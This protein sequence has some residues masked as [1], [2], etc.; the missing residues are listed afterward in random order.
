[1]QTNRLEDPTDIGSAIETTQNADSASAEGFELEVLGL[2]TGNLNAGLSAG[3]INAQFDD[4]PN[5]VLKGES[6]G[7]PNIVDV[8][9]QVLPRSPEWTFGANIDLTIPFSDDVEGYVRLDW[10]YVN[11][12]YSD[13]EAVGSLVGQTVTGDPFDLPDFPYNI[14]SYDITNLHFGV[15][16]FERFR[17]AAHVNNVFDKQYYTGTSD[18][19]G[20]AGIRLRPHFRTYTVNFTYQIY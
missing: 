20:A 11:K 9:G 5:A 1:M 18:N 14:D 3:Y 8:S 19:F 16:I 15:D 12:Q 6:G 13:I 2:I 7:N 4:F 17:V 10:A